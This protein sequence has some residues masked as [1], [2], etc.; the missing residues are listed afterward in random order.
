M[1]DVLLEDRNI[2]AAHPYNVKTPT[3]HQSKAQAFYLNDLDSL[4]TTMLKKT[5]LKQRR[6][7]QENPGP[8]RDTEDS[9]PSHQTT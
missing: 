5:P 1:I 2:T 3:S 6:L 9:I 8:Q 7:P 4:E